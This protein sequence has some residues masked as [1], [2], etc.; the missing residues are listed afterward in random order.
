[1]R[2]LMLKLLRALLLPTAVFFGAWLAAGGWSFAARSLPSWA[3]WV[4][5]FLL[6]GWVLLAVLRRTRPRADLSFG[7]AVSVPMTPIF[8]V[9]Y[10]GVKWRILVSYC[11]DSIFGEPTLGDFVEAEVPPTCPKCGVELEQSD[12]WGA[13]WRWRC[14][15]C[16]FKK[17]KRSSMYLESQRA[18]K[19]GK[20]QYELQR[21]SGGKND[22]QP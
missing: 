16:G 21:R 5:G 19:L 6:A 8:Q 20:A 10:S 18:E 12:L 15:C 2:E 7:G 9:T 1:M 11:T 22:R 4:S 17:L 3:M 14:V 13:F